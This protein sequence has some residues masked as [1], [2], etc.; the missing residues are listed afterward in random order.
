MKTASV[1]LYHNGKNWV[2][3]ILVSETAAQEELVISDAEA[4]K[5]KAIGVPVYE[6]E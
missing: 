3:N 5:L 4:D 2:L 6:G 1:E